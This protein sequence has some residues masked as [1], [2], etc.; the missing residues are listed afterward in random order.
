MMNCIGLFFIF[1]KIELQD[2]IVHILLETSPPHSKSPH[3]GGTA[4][5][6]RSQ[7]CTATATRWL[8]LFITTEC[9]M[10]FNPLQVS[11]LWPARLQTFFM[12]LLSSPRPCVQSN[13]WGHHFIKI[14]SDLNILLCCK[15][16]PGPMRR[17]AHCS[18]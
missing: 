1:F 8:N 3:T 18:N 12:S 17:T 14:P 9:F 4:C 2:M 5:L 16:C 15:S 11:L 7:L 10:I 6:N 13:D